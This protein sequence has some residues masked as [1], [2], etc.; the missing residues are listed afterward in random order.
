LQEAAADK[1]AII[2]AQSEKLGEARHMVYSVATGAFESIE[3]A[4]KTAEVL[5]AAW[6][7]ESES[8]AVE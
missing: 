2:E 7:A 6:E 1:D 8:E 3:A 5:V 4:M